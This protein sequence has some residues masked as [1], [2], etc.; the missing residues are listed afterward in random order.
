MHDAVR[1]WVAHHAAN[2]TGPVSVLEVGSLD[3]NGGVRDLF[4]N[5]DPYVGL[6]DV[7]GPGVDVVA[8]AAT[9][10][11]TRAFDVV[12]STEVLEHA[13][14]W[15]DIVA[16]CGRALRP[17]GVLILTCAG[18]GRGEHGQHGAPLPAPDEWY[19]NVSVGEL[20]A[21]TSRWG[22]G[23]IRQVGADTQAFVV[24]R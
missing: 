2:I 4:P 14:R 6:N 12:V 10:E 16:M 15:R 19:R 22:D 18:P 23:V 8:D 24:K 5:A 17:G 21:E 13:E 20:E 3:V 11:P 9:W 7:A 1:Q